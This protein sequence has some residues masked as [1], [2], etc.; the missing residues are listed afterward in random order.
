MQKFIEKA[1]PSK[2]LVPKSFSILWGRHIRQLCK[3]KDLGA[4]FKDNIFFGV[5]FQ[6]ITD[7]FTITG[8][9]SPLCRLLDSAN[10][11]VRE[12]KA[13]ASII[14]VKKWKS[15]MFAP[16]W[17]PLV[18]HTSLNVN[19]K[20]IIEIGSNESIVLVFICT[21]S[22]FACLAMYLATHSSYYDDLAVRQSMCGSM[23]RR[24]SFSPGVVFF[25]SSFHLRPSQLRLWEVSESESKSEHDLSDF[26]ALFGV[27]ERF[28]V[29]LDVDDGCMKECG[30]F[31][32][33]AYTYSSFFCLRKRD[34]VL[35]LY[36]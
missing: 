23:C 4:H 33:E 25:P 22:R 32:D 2:C 12:P 15:H 6:E 19:E 27:D 1:I 28:T 18:V 3:V 24:V 17:I 11:P 16:S 26:I 36:G 29:F 13:A 9:F 7:H 35:S 20:L 10:K 5:R 8:Q 21:W 14:F 30:A 31:S 34:W